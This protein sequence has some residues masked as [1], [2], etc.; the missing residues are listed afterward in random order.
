MR[1]ILGWAINS[2]GDFLLLTKIL[3]VIKNI[4][5][6]FKPKNIRSSGDAEVNAGIT[7]SA[8]SPSVP[9]IGLKGL[10]VGCGSL[11]EGM[12]RKRIW[13]NG[14]PRSLAEPNSLQ[15]VDTK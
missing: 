11:A 4:L 10:F 13:N 3:Q 5:S 7:F 6:S 1:F 9:E 12:D 14:I 2:L 8:S 15:M